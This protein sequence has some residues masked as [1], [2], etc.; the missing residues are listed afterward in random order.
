VGHDLKVRTVLTG[1]V[2]QRGEHLRIQADLV[3]IADG[4]ELWGQRYDRNAIDIFAIEEEIAREITDA[5][6]VRLS[7]DEEKRLG[8]RDTDSKEAY[9]LFLRGR[10]YWN[11]RGRE[12]LTRAVTCLEQAV[13]IDAGYA[14]AHAAIADCYGLYDAYGLGSAREYVPKAKKAAMKALGIEAS[15]AEPYA[16]LGLVKAYH[17]FDWLGAEREFRRAIELNPNYTPAR[18]WFSFPL[19]ATN[20]AEEA[21]ANIRHALEIEPLSLAAHTTL[22]G[23]LVQTRRY[24]EA[25]ELCRRTMELDPGF[26]PAHFVLA[27]VYG[28]TKMYREA[29]GELQEALRLSPGTAH[30]L[31]WLGYVY[32]I[33][34]A[35]EQAQK[36]LHELQQQSELRYVSPF[37]L[38]LVYLGLGERDLTFEWLE[39][40]RECRSFWLAFFIRFERLFAEIRSDKRF[41]ELLRGMNLEP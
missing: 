3:N 24:E 11:R 13:E 36:V 40:S 6:R 26:T 19:M 17:D 38:A 33:S 37:D 15:L 29:I 4:R 23:L 8:K 22:G 10:Y 31:G 1:K 20:R 5:L 9:Q 28:Q 32:G 16:C 27:L 2:L 39:G 7:G 12:T 18:T 21:V 30:F 34:G 35:R 41:R 25:T 14:L